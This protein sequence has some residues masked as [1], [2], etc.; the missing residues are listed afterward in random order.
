MALFL[1]SCELWFFNSIS[2]LTG[3]SYDLLRLF[4]LS[5]TC[6]FIYLFVVCLL[7]LFSVTVYLLVW[8]WPLLFVGLGGRL[9]FWL[10]WDSPPGVACGFGFPILLGWVS[11]NS[12]R[13]IL[14]GPGKV[15]VFSGVIYLLI[16]L[17]ILPPASRPFRLLA[18]GE[19]RCVS[20]CI[21][22]FPLCY[23]AY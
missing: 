14:G 5:L 10:R 18:L 20:P 16:Y 3:F 2:F 23:F 7:V 4:W 8:C 1:T 21:R 6:L 19:C 15:R 11:L 17:F 9:L 22:P 13:W 12:P